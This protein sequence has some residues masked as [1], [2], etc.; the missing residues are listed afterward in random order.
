MDVCSR[1]DVLICPGDT[2]LM[3]LG[4]KMGIPKHPLHDLGYRWECQVRPRSGISL[5]TDLRI[6]NAP[7]TIDNFYRDEVGVILY[8]ASMQQ[9]S[10]SE[11]LKVVTQPKVHFVLDLKGKQIPL[12]EVPDAPTIPVPYGTYYIR[13]GER[14]AQLVFNQVIRPMEIA[15][16]RIDDSDSR[17]GGFG[18]TGVSSL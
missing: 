11:L 16:G 14:I 2:K 6:A 13:K 3:K 8:N 7:G 1:Y 9:Y 10:Y 4:F 15:E 17:G 5:K 18:S 12:S